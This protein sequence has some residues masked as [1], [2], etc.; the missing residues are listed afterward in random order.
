MKYVTQEETHYPGFVMPVAITASIEVPPAGDG[1][2]AVLFWRT[3]TLILEDGDNRFVFHG[4]GVVCVT[5]GHTICS[6]SF[7]NSEDAGTTGY[8]LV[9]RPEALNTHH[10]SLPDTFEYGALTNIDTSFTYRYLDEPTAIRLENLCKGIDHQLNVEKGIY[11]PCLSRSY[12]LELLLLVERTR[13]STGALSE[14]TIPPCGEQIRDIFQY[15]HTSYSGD[16]SLSS[17][18]DRF[19]TNRTTLNRQFRES[20]GMTVMAYLAKIR[21]D[22]AVLLLQNTTISIQDISRRIGLNDE[23]YFSRLFRNR[24]GLPPTEFRRKYPHPYGLS[25]SNDVSE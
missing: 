24:T 18:A 12:I 22:V 7:Q 2:Y 21:L 19:A 23:A 11:W 20:C 5:P 15:I 3:G 17:L 8:T 4:P 14:Y 25:W 16:I 9:F 1:Y 10:S 6:L 13:Y